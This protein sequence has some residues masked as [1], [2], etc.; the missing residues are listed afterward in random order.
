MGAETLLHAAKLHTSWLEL[1]EAEVTPEVADIFERT[2]ERFG[3]VRNSQLVTAVNPHLAVAQDRLSHAVQRAP[4]ISLS[5]LDRELI[6]VV[7]SA[8]NRCAPCLFVHGAMLRDL[9]GDPV[10]VARLEINDRHVEL[11][12]RHRALADYARKITTAP[13]EIVA[14][15]IDTLRSAG[16]TEREIFDAAAVAAYFNFS[17]RINNA[18]GIKP[19]IEAFQANR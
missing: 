11:S 4:S 1:P 2:Q 6:A 8:Q 10:L 16:L 19:D 3:H 7:V 15:D 18:L 9:T 17:N 5:D 13:E 12:Q 14:G